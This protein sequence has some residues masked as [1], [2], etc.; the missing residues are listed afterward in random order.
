MPPPVSEKNKNNETEKSKTDSTPC[1]RC[2]ATERDLAPTQYEDGCDPGRQMRARA[3]P[4]LEEDLQREAAETERLD[5]DAAAG[6]SMTFRYIVAD[7][8]TTGATAYDKVC[9]VAWVELDADMQVLDR[10]HSLIDPQMPISAGASGVHGITNADVTEAPTIDEFFS[11]VLGESH[12]SPDDRVLLIAHNAPFDKRY[13]A[14]HMPIKGE[15]CTL[16]LA[17]RVWP[18]AENH[19]LA[20]L[21]YLLS[22]SRGKS[23]SA[24]GDV[25]TCLDLLRKIVW[26]TG[27]SLNDLAAVS[28]EPVWVSTMPFGK[29]KGSPLKVLPV[30]YIKWLLGLDNLDMD[31]RHSLDLVMQGNAP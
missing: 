24:H 17:R 8:E 5:A 23:H 14:P 19:K 4:V 25:E 26:K 31:M 10:Q 22:L 9:E 6:N 3:A 21:M 12:F 1:A 28:M 20:T 27:S 15:L 11:L 2:R 18:E 30:S 7:T 13:L 16:R 29:H